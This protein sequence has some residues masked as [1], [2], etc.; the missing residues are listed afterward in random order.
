MEFRKPVT[1]KDIAEICG[2]SIS[3]VSRALNN[4]GYVDGEKRK[5]IIETAEKLGYVPQPVAMSLQERRTKQILFYCK[6][7]NNEYNIEMYRGMCDVANERGYMVVMNGVVQFER[8]KD[9]MIDGIIMPNENLT[10]YYMKK[11]GKNYYLPVVSSSYCNPVELPKSVPLVEVDMYRAMEIGI[12]YL[13]KMGHEKIAFGFPYSIGNVNSRLLSFKEQ[14]EF[15][16]GDKWKNYVLNVQKKEF[17]D[18]KGLDQL[19]EDIQ[20]NLFGI[21]EDFFEKG[22]VAAQIFIERELDATAVMCFNDELALGMMKEFSKSGIQVPDDISIVGIDGTCTRKY[23]VPLLTT[24]EIYPRKHG[25]ECA[26]ILIDMIEKK[27]KKFRV[28]LTAR[29][30][31]GE[32]V[33][34][35]T[36][37]QKK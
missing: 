27:N 9:T 24:V 3:V 6:D 22:R 35:L 23:V 31:E 34:N 5:K 12:N 1:R 8:I 13:F 10:E 33:K 28:H 7:L 16:L 29:L 2:V 36:E 11:K 19:P 25:S 26:K 15:R 17:A 21:E 32:S 37:A 30:L 4:S 20:D 14:M 18:D